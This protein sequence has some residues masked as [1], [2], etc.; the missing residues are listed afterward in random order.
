MLNIVFKGNYISDDQLIK[1]CDIPNNA[2]EYGI[3]SSLQKEFGRGLII[4]MPLFAVMVAATYFKIKD[5][6]YHLT[7]GLD[8]AVSFV[9]V[10]VSVY[11][12]TF[13][14]EIIHALFY[15]ADA[16][17]EIWK[18]KEQGAYFVYC[19]KEI[20][21]ERFIIMCLAPM[22]IL[23]IIP[24][25]VWLILPDFIPM[26]YNIAVP[27]VFWLMTIMAMGDVANVY[28]V[29]K[30]VPKG[31]NVFNHGLLRSFYIENEK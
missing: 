21:R 15:P 28:H 11:L 22:F 23:G 30:E 4:L 24:F 5:L 16:V 9:L 13:V 25:A 19:E 17:K 31:S 10:I 3:V 18:S 8:V 6:D 27:I 26:P 12:L 1:R 20:S 7:M 2:V 14:H 29:I